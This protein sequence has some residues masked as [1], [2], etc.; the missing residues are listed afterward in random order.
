[1]GNEGSI[2]KIYG[3]FGISDV[4]SKMSR[5][6]SYEALNESGR[7]LEKHSVFFEWSRI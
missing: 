4:K 2:L 7:E 5:Y 1:M 3:C 6:D